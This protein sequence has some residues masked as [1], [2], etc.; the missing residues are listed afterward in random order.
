[1]FA[2]VNKSRALV[3][4]GGSIISV[5][6]KQLEDLRSNQD[7]IKAEDEVLASEQARIQEDRDAMDTQNRM[8]ESVAG[9]L[10]EILGLKDLAP[11][12]TAQDIMNSEVEFEGSLEEE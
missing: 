8:N 10:E 12:E 2:K 1:M 7:A 4:K 9:K 3:A 6:S 5:F 11:C